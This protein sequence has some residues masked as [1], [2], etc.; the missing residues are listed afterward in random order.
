MVL[1]CSSSDQSDSTDYPGD[2]LATI[3]AQCEFSLAHKGCDSKCILDSLNINEFG[4]ADCPGSEE[5]HRQTD[6]APYRTCLDACTVA[7][8]CAPQAGKLREC[9]CAGMCASRLSKRTQG[10]MA[11]EADCYMQLPRCQ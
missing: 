9:A 4:G 7:K 8:D 3:M 10:M 5:V 11:Y 6:L 2:P 1:G